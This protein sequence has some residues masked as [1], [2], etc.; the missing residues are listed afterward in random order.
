[1]LQF[2]DPEGDRRRIA[3]AREV[4][5]EFGVAAECGFGRTDPARLPALLANHRAAAEMLRDEVR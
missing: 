3:L 4:L 5:T 2:N 1:L